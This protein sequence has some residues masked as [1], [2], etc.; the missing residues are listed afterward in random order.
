MNS[1][2]LLKKQQKVS[3]LIEKGK[4]NEAIKPLLQLC[5]LLPDNKDLWLKLA[6]LYG[7]TNDMNNV[8]KVCKKIEPSMKNNPTVYSMQGNAYASLN[9][10]EKAYECYQHALKL[11][12][13]DPALLNNLANAYYIDARYEEA[14]DIFHRVIK[15]Q[16]DYADANNNLG[17]IYKALNDNDLA[18]KYYENAVRLNPMLFQTLLN[19]A[20]MFADRIGHPEIA[21]MYFRKALAIEPDNMEALSGITNMLRFQGKLDAALEMIKQVQQLHPEEIGTI[22]AEAD[23]YERRGDY[24]KA[25]EMCI[26]LL[27][28]PNTHPMIIDVLLRVCARFDDCDRALEQGEILLDNPGLSVTHKQNTHFALGKLYDKLGRYDDAFRNYKAGNESTNIPYDIDKHIE[29]TD[30]LITHFSKQNIDKLPKSSIDTSL[31]VFILGMPRSGTSL[32]EQILSSHP[33]VDG[34]GEL[35]DINDIIAK[36]A[37]VLDSQTPYPQCIE[38]LSTEVMDNL[39]SEY[40]NKLKNIGSGG[41]RHITDKMPHNFLNIGLISLLFP[42]A[43][44]IHCTRDPRDTCLSVFFQSFGWLHPYGTKLEWLGSYYR[45]YIRLM[46][47]WKSASNIEIHTVSY[48]DMVNDQEATTRSMLD[49][50]NL[51]WNDA[52]L[53]F[54]KSKRHIATASYD[55]VKQKLYKKS[56][57]RWKNYESHIQPL[58]D[59]LGNVIDNN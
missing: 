59:N 35:N 36:L 43:R 3:Y 34:A 1:S 17:N 46:E 8:I 44:I 16:P 18:I 41:V 27:T 45:Q 39:A 55:Q 30:D 9:Q 58:I 23:I 29:R 38:K 21:E 10:M 53:N 4:L 11:Q 25:H 26:D 33:D 12:P 6:S 20:Q 37:K 19:L 49:Y 51:E 47:H 5:K 54:H 22:A 57:A 32:T 15:I 2:Q 40:L 56:Q 42:Q 13:D 7:Q 31:P 24:D 14:A 48:E 28:P 52:C 50:C